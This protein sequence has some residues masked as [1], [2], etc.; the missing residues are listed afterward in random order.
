MAGAQTLIWDYGLAPI[1]AGAYTSI[2]KGDGTVV[3][4]DLQAALSYGQMAKTDR[5]F[6]MHLREL[7]D[8][9]ITLNW[10]YL[11]VPYLTRTTNVLGAIDHGGLSTLSREILFPWHLTRFNVP[12]RDHSPLN[13]I[14]LDKNS[15][16]MIV[17]I[18][19]LL[20]LQF[21]GGVA[22]LPITALVTLMWAVP[23]F[24]LGFPRVV[25]AQIGTTILGA[26]WL[27]SDLFAR[28][29]KG[30]TSCTNRHP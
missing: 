15:L 12:N 8:K 30:A 21:Q 26:V 25:D 24:T 17:G 29:D 10:R 7:Y 22:F 20:I 3:P 18:L 4:L 2:T 23:G 16:L 5:E 28:F 19:G 9:W 6:Y 13:L 1:K 11:W 14:L 27:L